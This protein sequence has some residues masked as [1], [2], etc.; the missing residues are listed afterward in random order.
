MAVYEIRN[1]KFLIRVTDTLAD[2]N[3][4]VSWSKHTSHLPRLDPAKLRIIE[5][6]NPSDLTFRYLLIYKLESSAAQQEV[7]AAVYFQ[8]L[9]F[10]SRNFHFND[11]TL[12]QRMII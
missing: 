1:E 3:F 10:G 8:V 4:R 9:N 11:P 7:V 2:D 5:R 12:F 6:S